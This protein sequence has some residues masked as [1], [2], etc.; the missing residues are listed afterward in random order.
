[1]KIVYGIGSVTIQEEAAVN[2][3]ITIQKSLKKLIGELYLD[4]EIDIV[5][6]NKEFKAKRSFQN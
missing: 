1:M 5:R 3:Y 6:C 2:L 4:R